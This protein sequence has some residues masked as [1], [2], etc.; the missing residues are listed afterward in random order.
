MAWK[1]N[2][3]HAS[4]NESEGLGR[5]LHVA[6]LRGEAELARLLCS[7][8]ECDSGVGLVAWSGVTA[9]DLAIF[10]GFDEGGEA[11]LQHGA[12]LRHFQH[13]SLCEAVDRGSILLL[14]AL[15]QQMGIRS[16]AGP[17]ATDVLNCANAEGNTPLHLACLLP[18]REAAIKILV[19]YNADPNKE[20][21]EGM[22]PLDCCVHTNNK[23]AW[24]LYGMRP[25]GRLGTAVMRQSSDRFMQQ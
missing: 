21:P 1:A 23:S 7:R 13:E 20:N 3:H 19:A 8:G 6:V 4:P 24:R 18:D 25:T 22:T 17:F 12:L 14:R 2:A 11:L 16:C 10:R 5:A 9:L 15:L